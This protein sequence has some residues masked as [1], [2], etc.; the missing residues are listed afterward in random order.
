MLEEFQTVFIQMAVLFTIMAVG[1][2]AKKIGIMD[3]DFDKKFSS[4]VL[5]T[6]L[7]ALILASVLDAEEL[8]SNAEILQTLLYSFLALIL[9]IVAA[10][11]LC[12]LLRVPVGHRGVYRFMLAFA[13]TGFL[14]YPVITSI[15]GSEMLIYACIYNLPFNFFVFSVGVWFIASDNEFGVKVKMSLKDFLS[16]CIV[17]SIITIVLALLGVHDVPVLGDALDTLGSLTT[18]AALLIVGSSLANLPARE[19]LGTPRLWVMALCRLLL[20]PAI[21]WGVFHFFAS[22]DLLSMLVLLAGMPIA[23]NGT[24]LCYRYGGDAKTMS[25]GTFITTVLS[26][27]TIPLIAAILMA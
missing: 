11:L 16:P 18:P 25:Q 17:C 5:N 19:L 22:G 15:F 27:F 13:N 26:L 21:T 12:A 24:M 4:L 9:L 2:A 1:Y 8:P 10:M 23:T 3:A 14:G 20:M 7:P 6:S